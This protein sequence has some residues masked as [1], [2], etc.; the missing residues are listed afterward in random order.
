MINYSFH[1][2]QPKTWTHVAVTYNIPS[3]EANIYV[4]G[5]QQTKYTVT[6]QGA[7]HARAKLSQNWDE[8]VSIGRS[9]VGSSVQQ[10]RQ[11]VGK[12]AEFYLYPCALGPEQVLKLKEKKCMESKCVE[13]FISPLPL[14]LSYPPT[15]LSLFLRLPDIGIDHESHITNTG[16]SNKS[17]T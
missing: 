1:S 6:T 8:E 7:N 17:V 4:N 15:H 12:L 5:V 10:A 9:V 3:T 16:T 13:M 2:F 14:T 11:L